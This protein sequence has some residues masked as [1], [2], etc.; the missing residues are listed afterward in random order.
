MYVESVNHADKVG[1]FCS[2]VASSIL[3]CSLLNS[4]KGRP[5]HG[6]QQPYSEQES[7]F[8]L[9]FFRYRNLGAERFVWILCCWSGGWDQVFSQQFLAVL[10]EVVVDVP[11][12]MPGTYQQSS[13][14]QSNGRSGWSQKANSCTASC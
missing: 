4:C 10:S 7:T 1:R 11:A 8:L 2:D 13:L 6:I 12:N 9:H 14:H 3:G 5:F